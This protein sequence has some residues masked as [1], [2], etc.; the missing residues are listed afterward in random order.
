MMAALTVNNILRREAYD[1]RTTR[2]HQESKSLEIYCF[3]DVEQ[4]TVNVVD[5]LAPQ[6]AQ[7]LQLQA[8]F[9][10]PDMGT[11]HPFKGGLRLIV[12]QWTSID[13]PDRTVV[14]FESEQAYH[15]MIDALHLPREYP[16]LFRHCTYLAPRVSTRREGAAT[17]T[18]IMFQGINFNT[19]FTTLA[20]CYNSETKITSGF[21]GYMCGTSASDRVPTQGILPSILVSA[22][23]A[24]HPLTV[25]LLL[26]HNFVG[27]LGGEARTQDYEQFEL[28][29]EINNA[30]LPQMIDALDF[31]GIHRRLIKAHNSLA[32]LMAPFIRDSSI[33]LSNALDEMPNFVSAEDVPRLDGTTKALKQ[34]FEQMNLRSM[35][36]LQLR[37]KTL[38]RMN[39]QLKVLFN[40]IQQ[41]D[42]KRNHDLATI[43]SEMAKQSTTIIESTKRDSEAMKAIAIL[44]MLFL[45][46][47]AIAAIFSMQLFFST[48][49][50]A[51][52]PIVI[53]PSFWVYWAVTIPLTLV[54][55]LIWFIWIRRDD[56][57]AIWLNGVKVRALWSW[58]SAA[59]ATATASPNTAQ[60]V[61]LQSL[62]SLP[63][64]PDASVSGTT[65][66]TTRHEG[67]V[68]R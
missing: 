23:Q 57:K 64:N 13:L 22:A 3:E 48:S 62:P 18:S 28:S 63:N 60:N 66:Q 49:N 12:Q 40:L 43:S 15:G 53:N 29:R 5:L 20:L 56:L 42:N 55:L 10:R 54:V 6:L 30:I 1:G 27:I 37:E 33:A 32:N 46:G 51:K 58:K 50:D 36:F 61:D 16:Y 9:A 4:P 59:T 68:V 14:P 47:T 7:W 41:R 45:P 24:L 67:S 8:P 38:S 21:L 31:P 26:F 35:G 44:T 34:C 65:I 17:L 25:P 2:V 11:E 39:I 19:S 52:I